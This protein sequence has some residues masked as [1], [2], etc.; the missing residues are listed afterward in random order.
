M[1]RFDSAP[2]LL[3][4]ILICLAGLTALV[5]ATG[6]VLTRQKAAT[7]RLSKAIDLH[8]RSC[9]LADQIR[10]SSDDLTRMVRTYAVTGDSTFEEHFYTI[11]NIR[12]G[13]VPRPEHY[14]FIF[15]DFKVA[16]EAM[17]GSPDGKKIS[18]RRLMEDAEF[19]DE[20]F[21]LLAE[22]KRRS[23]RLVELEEVAMNAMKGKFRDEEGTFTKIKAPDRELALQIL[24]GEEYHQAK[25]DIMKPIDEFLLASDKRTTN[26]L[27]DAQEERRSLSLALVCL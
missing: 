26:A 21:E 16:G 5:L 11:L 17:P 13:K 8:D 4:L 19:A 20:E 10:Q 9:R 18:L 12:D 23:D 1:N 25:S 14:D 27:A 22:A 24:F 6:Y 7:N 3:R 15:W 2:F